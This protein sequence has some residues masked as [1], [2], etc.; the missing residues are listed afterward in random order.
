[1]PGIDIATQGV[2]SSTVVARGFNNIFSGSLHALTDNRIAG[3]PSLRVNLL[4]FVPTTND[5]VDRMEVVLGPGAALYGPNTTDGVLHIITKS[6]LDYQET[7]ATIG[8][9]EQGLFQ[10][11]FR[12]SQLL[13]ENFGLKISG[14]YM[15]ADEWPYRDPVELAER[16]NYDTIPALRGQLRN[17]LGL[18]DN[19]EGNAEVDRRISRIATRDFN[20][21]RWSADLRADWR[22]AD[23]ATVVF[24]GGLSH[25]G[26][27][28]ELTGLGGAQAKDWRYGYLQ[29]RA[30]WGRLFAQAY[31][32]ASDAGDTYLL[33]NG[34]PIT[35]RSKLYVAQIQHGFDFGERQRFTY[36]L[37]FIYTNPITEGTIN[38]GYEDDDQTTE[39]GGYLQS[40]TVLSP[41]FSLVL[42]GRLDHHSALPEVVFSPRAGLV[43]K[44][45]ENQ[46]FRLTY[47]RAFST[48][49]SLNQWLDLGS[50]IPNPAAAALGYSLRVQGT[51]KDGFH[52]R[53]SDGSYLIRSPFTPIELGGPGTLLPAD[54]TMFWRAAVQVVA[55]QANLGSTP[56]G[57]ALVNY[58]LGLTPTREDIGTN[59]YHP[60]TEVVGPLSELALTGLDPIRESTTTTIEAGYKGVLGDRLLL[61]ADVW[62]SRKENMVTPLLIQTPFVTLDGAQT[63]AYLV[64]QLTAFFQAAGLPADQAQAQAEATVQQLA[65]G[66][67]SVPVGV[68]SS[69]DVH[70]N[71]AQLLTTYINVDDNFDLYGFD[72]AATAL[73]DDNWSLTGTLSLVNENLFET[74]KGEQVTLNAPK[75]KGSIALGYR[76]DANGFNGELRA[77]YHDA[78]PVRSGVYNGVLC[79]ASSDAERNAMRVDGA[80]DCVASSTLVDLLIGYRLPMLPNATLQLSVQNVLDEAYRSF[81][82]VPTIGRMALFQLKYSF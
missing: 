54:A 39:F 12:T 78:F 9:G 57:Q 1:V 36:G 70:A 64:P 16:A 17:A 69:D 26:N 71:G 48:P 38:G 52:F 45:D 29:A 7:T 28:I 43:F 61:A 14:Q 34:A 53:Q 13:S 30:T 27:G 65:P 22:I 58:L 77:R 44:P 73:L 21:S 80:E 66:L 67:A 51:G 49:S 4:Q 56:Q 68:I 46:A 31:M 10:A 33:R 6:P 47:N 11:A 74:K 18:P 19:A 32:N 81:P 5:D 2:Q 23:D 63:A 41:K 60:Q 3:I 50:A 15:Q 75:T 24:A 55:Q 72:L 42:A 76:N 35:D 82:G 37:D 62:Y 59:Y 8:G 79:L 20:L 40:E 25:I